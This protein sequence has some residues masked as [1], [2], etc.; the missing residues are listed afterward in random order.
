MKGRRPHKGAS[1]RA[2]LIHDY[3]LVKKC[4]FIWGDPMDRVRTGLDQL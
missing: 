1:Y 2:P 3:E 4:G